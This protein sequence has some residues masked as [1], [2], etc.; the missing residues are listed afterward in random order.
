LT[1][2]FPTA[3]LET[4]GAR[5]GVVRR[6]AVIYFGGGDRITIAASHAG[7]PR[8]P[9]W[10]YNLLAHPDVTFG[11]VPM[12]ATVVDEAEHDR[13]WAIGD[14]VFPGYERCRRDAAEAGRTIPLIRL[15]PKAGG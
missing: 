14:R 12:R 5:T 11:G 1:L 7:S 6:N 10:Y 4:R 15:T 2:V 9:G 8:H 13:L 3:V